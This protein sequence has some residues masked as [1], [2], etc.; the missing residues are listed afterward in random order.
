METLRSMIDKGWDVNTVDTSKDK[1]KNK[2]GSPALHWAAGGGHLGI[3]RVLKEKGASLQHTRRDG[4]NALHWAARS[5]SHIVL[6][7]IPH[8]ARPPPPPRHTHS[9]LMAAPPPPP[10][11]RTPARAHTYVCRW[12]SATLHSRPQSSATRMS[13]E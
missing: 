5:V 11:A 2:N 3:C 9:A 1:D 7:P 8:T 13:P 6:R 12:P 4:R 10:A